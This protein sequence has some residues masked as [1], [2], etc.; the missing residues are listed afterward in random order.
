MT[1]QYKFVVSG[2]DRPWLIDV[3]NDPGEVNNLFG[4][5]KYTKLVAQMRAGLVRY[6]R[7]HSDTHARIPQIQAQLFSR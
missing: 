7:Q 1:G 4:D 5:P 3:Q 2:S 6:V